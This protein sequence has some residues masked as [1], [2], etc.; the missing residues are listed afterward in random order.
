MIYLLAFPNT[1][2]RIGGV[3]FRGVSEEVWVPS[4]LDKGVQGARLAWLQVDEAG[5]RPS[6]CARLWWVVV[7]RVLLARL[8]SLIK[9]GAGLSESDSS[10]LKIIL[11]HFDWGTDDRLVGKCFTS[12]N[13][14]IDTGDS[15]H[16]TG[17][18]QPVP[19]SPRVQAVLQPLDKADLLQCEESSTLVGSD[20]STAPTP[21]TRVDEDGGSMGVEVEEHGRGKRV[22]YSSVK[23]NDDVMNTMQKLSPSSPSSSQTSGTLYPLT[24]SLNCNRF[25]IEHR[26]FLAALT[27]CMGPRSF[28]ESMQSPHWQ[29]AMKKEVELLE[30]NGTWSVV[31]LPEGNKALGAQW[32]YKVEEIDYNDTFAPVAK[33]VTVRTFLAVDAVKNWELHQMDIHNA[34]LHGDLSEEIF[35]WLPPSFNKGRPG[36]VCKSNICMG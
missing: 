3:I 17:A 33:M 4:R 26:S 1:D 18:A 21:G 27:A 11:G 24:N 20:R 9:V 7:S 2:F 5:T 28:K 13:W 23:L 25:S 29:E 16:V 6:P 22:K 15:S 32:V 30:D 34:F 8:D 10:K 12:S 36:L 35:M 19:S 14:V 31:K